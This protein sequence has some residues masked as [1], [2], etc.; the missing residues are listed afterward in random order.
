MIELGDLPRAIS[1]KNEATARSAA[2]VAIGTFAEAER[3][4]IARAL[5]MASGNKVH[6]HP[7][8]F[9]QTALRKDRKIR[10]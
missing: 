2:N 7:Q 8:D 9:A 4:I 1:G 10:A 3:D 6:S 5:E